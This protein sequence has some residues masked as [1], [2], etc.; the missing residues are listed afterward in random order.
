[1]S[2]ETSI[3]L[4]LLSFILVVFIYDKS[5]KVNR[6]YRSILKWIS[7]SLLL[8]L[9]GMRKNVGTDY[10][11]YINGFYLPMKSYSI[12]ESFSK[13]Y[14]FLLIVKVAIIFDNYKILFF[15]L[16]LITLYFITKALEKSF[17]KYKSLAF[18]I[19]IFIFYL[20]TW[21][22][23]RQ[24]ICIAIFLYSIDYIYGKKLTHF[25]IFII[26]GS[27]IHKSILIVYPFYFI[28]NFLLK[29]NKNKKEKK[30]I[31]ILF[32]LISF[33]CLL[34]YVNIIKILGKIIPFFQ[35]YKLYIVYN[36][37]SNLI[38]LLKLFL[39]TIVLPFRRKLIKLNKK[40]NL[41]VLF[42]IT[43]FLLTLLGFYNIYVKRISSYFYVYY[44]LIIPQFLELFPKY[45]LCL[46]ILIYIVVI[47]LCLLQYY[48]LGFAEVI[49]YQV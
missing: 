8:L 15:L 48:I 35:K 27:F 42:I 28:Y 3:L 26:I 12:F 4:Y 25:T 22:I 14:L 23:M 20:E 31:I 37:S 24:H 41:L 16:N 17:I 36:F 6:K 18:S 11:G 10:L 44:I 34:N 1:V 40:N 29:N 5:Y 39:L 43:D 2:N 47:I 45:N 7:L 38:I 9:A 21:N 46:K 13:E 30:I 19:Y 49:P 32:Y 33:I